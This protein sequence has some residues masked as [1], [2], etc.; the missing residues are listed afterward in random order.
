[1]ARVGASGCCSSLLKSKLSRQFPSLGSTLLCLLWSLERPAW[2]G[3][4]LWQCPGVF[5]TLSDMDTPFSPRM[6]GKITSWLKPTRHSLS[7]WCHA[8]AGQDSCHL[9]P[10]GFLER[11]TVGTGL[12]SSRLP[13]SWMRMA[14]R[15]G[16]RSLQDDCRKDVHIALSPGSSTPEE[17]VL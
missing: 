9:Y 10:P 1:M 2:H 5:F 13:V 15:L 11:P 14:Y 4:L 3:L 12:L 17:G 16:W 8:H 6:I 7:P